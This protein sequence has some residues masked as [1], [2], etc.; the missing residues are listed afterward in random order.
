MRSKKSQISS[1]YE[2]SAWN[3]P[4]SS[5]HLVEVLFLLPLLPLF[6]GLS[7]GLA[8]SPFYSASEAFLLT[9]EGTSF[10][11][12][13]LSKVLSIPYLTAKGIFFCSVETPLR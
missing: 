6:V 12:A 3:S 9:A 4:S 8:P 2:M 11:S 10:I 5:V 7:N 1:N 13:I